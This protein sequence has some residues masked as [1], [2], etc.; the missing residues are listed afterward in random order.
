MTPGLHPIL[1]CVANDCNW[2]IATTV[3]GSA[4]NGCYGGWEADVK[5]SILPHPYDGTR[6]S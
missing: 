1:T 3:S 4:L 6:P 2:S 5:L